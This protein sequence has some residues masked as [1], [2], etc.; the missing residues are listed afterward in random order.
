[1]SASGDV[2]SRQVLEG[3]YRRGWPAS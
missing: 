1:M 2:N 3:D